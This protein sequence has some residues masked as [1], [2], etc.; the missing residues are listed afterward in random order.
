MDGGGGVDREFLSRYTNCACLVDRVVEGC[1]KHMV[2][3]T[4]IE[5]LFVFVP[6]DMTIAKAKIGSSQMRSSF[7]H[8]PISTIFSS[9]SGDPIQAEGLSLMVGCSG[10]VEA[11]SRNE[12][13]SEA[14]KEGVQ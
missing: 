12:E 14:R 13:H 6:V 10:S 7:L 1:A 9:C 11:Q 3:C 5:N 2:G 8:S 4:C